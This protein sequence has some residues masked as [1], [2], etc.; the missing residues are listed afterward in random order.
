MAAAFDDAAIFQ[1]GRAIGIE[2]RAF[3][4]N[5]HAALDFWTPN[6]NPYKDPRWGRGHETPGED[7]LMSSRYVKAFISGMQ[8]N[9]STLR[10]LPTCKH[11]AGYDEEATRYS[12]NAE[13]S[14]QDLAE[15]Y[16]PPF[17]ACTRDA[18]AASVMCS[19]NSVNGQPSCANA[20]LLN[21]IL[22]QHWGWTDN[23]QYIVS[24]CDAVSFIYNEHHYNTTYQAA[25]AAAFNA[26]TDNLCAGMSPDSTPADA[27]NA[28]DFS[29][30]TLDKM[31]I[32]QYQG[33]I[34]A[35]YFDGPSSIYRNLGAEDLN[36]ASA[37]DLALQIAQE[38]VVLLKNDGFLPN[39][40]SDAPVAMIGFWADMGS[41]MLGGYSGRAPRTNSPVYVAKNM[42]I[43]V[44]YATGPIAQTSSDNWT[45]A[46]MTAA[47]NSAAII[48]FAGIDNTIE[49]EQTDRT[50][51]S[52]PGP[53]LA[54][55]QKLAVL[56]KPI[57]IVKMGTHIDD[58]PLLN[59]T[60]I[61]AI[62]WAGYP[63]QDGGTAVM[64][65][66]TGAFAASGRL[67]MTMY[68]S[69]YASQVS[70]TDM[71]LRPSS[72]SPGRTYRWYNTPVFPFGHG[73][74]YTKWNLSF[75]SV[76]S[77]FSIQDLMAN[78]TEVFRD[79]CPFQEIPITITNT[80]SVSSDFVVLAF[81]SGSYGPTPYPIKTLAA[82]QR[83]FKIDVGRSQNTKLSMVLGDLGRVDSTGSRILVS[84]LYVL[85]FLECML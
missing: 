36:S 16:L 64:N 84:N 26:G 63:G 77:S 20:Y 41:K 4:N 68:P 22:R 79:L 18:K 52:W 15:Y 32:R 2:A 81:V 29:Q 23:N 60:N 55:I 51:I 83:L 19:Y 43:K 1:V 50:T 3:G 48:F 82:Y 46:A 56:G 67:P 49:K 37:K 71:T 44:N 80:G 58:S 27:F 11:Y 69:S 34:R 72:R 31:M 76:P 28:G 78:C 62:V 25:V 65:V 70:I 38:G 75:G 66:L 9:A 14:I 53:Q 45:S 85:E 39:S 57:V 74:S 33:L 61:K 40:F 17:Q 13:I 54:L 21:T 8:G 35:G 24:D 10:V 12:F 47:Q 59:T 30:E 42:G 5:G 6:I 73:L 7:P